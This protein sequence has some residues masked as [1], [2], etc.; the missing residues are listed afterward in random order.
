MIRRGEQKCLCHKDAVV[1]HV[2]PC[3]TGTIEGLLKKTSPNTRTSNQIRSEPE[4]SAFTHRII[5][6]S[7]KEHRTP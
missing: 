4:E 7:S 3:C 5:S 6:S 1:Q 2:V